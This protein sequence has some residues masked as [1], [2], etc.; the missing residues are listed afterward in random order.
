MDPMQIIFDSDSSSSSSSHSDDE[1]KAVISNLFLPEL[2]KDVSKNNNFCEETVPSYT[3]KQFVEHFRVSR[4][5]VATLKRD[6][7]ES[8]F[9]SK[10]DTGFQRIDSEKCILAFLWFTSNEGAAFRDVADRFDLS[11]SILHGIVNIVHFLSNLS[12]SVIV[13]PLAPEA[14]NI[15][16]IFA[17]M[18]FPGAIGCI[19]GSHIKIDTPR[20]DPD[21]YLNRKKFHSIQISGKFVQYPAIL[22][23]YMQVICDDNRKI[24][25]VF[26]G[27]PGSVHDAR[28]FRNSPLCQN[29]GQWCK[30]WVILGDSA[31]P[32]LR[33]LLTPYKETGSLSQVQKSV[34]KKLSHCRVLIEHTI[35]LLKQRFRQLYHFKSRDIKFICHFIRACCV[36]DNLCIDSNV[37]LDE[38]VDVG[39]EGNENPFNDHVQYDGHN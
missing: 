11:M 2:L 29:L 37:V 23:Q 19:D 14:N 15:A 18:R 22:C 32:C 1:L 20:E 9:Y 3:D 36:L 31:H 17:E 39:D 38:A 4:Q 16:R 34:N 7:E 12:R 25:D 13:W 8:E 35:G 33:N 24:K 6:F 5:I 26:I 30:D 27:Y 28:V 10:K 21:S